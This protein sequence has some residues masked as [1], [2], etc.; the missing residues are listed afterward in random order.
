M[1]E[2][3]PEYE[4]FIICLTWENIFAY[5]SAGSCEDFKNE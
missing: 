3:S 4:R 2:P 5:S 1:A